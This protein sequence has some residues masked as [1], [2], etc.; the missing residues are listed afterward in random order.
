MM[1][2]NS[3]ASSA[4]SLVSQLT[5]QRD[6]KHKGSTPLHLAAS[7]NGWPS[8]GFLS[9]RFP[10]VWP[11]AESVATLL[12]DANESTAYQADDQRWYPIHVPAAFDSLGIVKVLLDMESRRRRP[13]DCATLRDGKGRTF[14][15]VAAEMKS[16]RCGSICLW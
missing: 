15:H 8:A 1:T 2:G 16:H 5:N 3:T 10:K 13:Q 12:L 14:L 6:K 11:T 9:S 4:S 7:L